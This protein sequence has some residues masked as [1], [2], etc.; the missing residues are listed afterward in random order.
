[1]QR[2]VRLLVQMLCGASILLGVVVIG[3]AQSGEAQPGVLRNPLNPAG[4]PDPWL[5]YYEGNYYLATTTGRS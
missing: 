4:G 2:Q 3:Q 1:M 5:V